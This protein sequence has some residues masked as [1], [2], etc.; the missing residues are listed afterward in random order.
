MSV[1]MSTST[2][3]RGAPAAGSCCAPST[4]L[5]PALD[6]ER[7]A[8]LAKA[9]A[10]PVRVNLLD[11]LRRHAEPLCQCELRPLFGITQP[12]LSHH[13]SKLVDAGLVE[14][15]RR[16]RWA[17]YSVRPDTLEELTAWLS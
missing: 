16:H 15:E 14:V 7:L 3:V 17:Y 8:T 13:M 1:D 10:E 9:L 11:V 5:D 2:A 12:L 4:G 6:A